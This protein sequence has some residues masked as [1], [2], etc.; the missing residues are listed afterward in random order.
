MASARPPLDS[1]ERRLSSGDDDDDDGDD[2]DGDDDDDDDD[3][4]KLLP[5][6]QR[7]PNLPH[8][9]AYI[10]LLGPVVPQ[11]HVG[12]REGRSL[13][14]RERAEDGRHAAVLV[15]DATAGGCH[16]DAPGA[17]EIGDIVHD[18]R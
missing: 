8:R 5:P 4:A 6:P 13:A 3:D 11:R 15:V 1:A 18:R 12:V 14:G 16:L 10:P 7:V 2:G 9:L 17:F